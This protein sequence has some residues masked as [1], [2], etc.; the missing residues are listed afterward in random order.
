MK[1][2]ATLAVLSF[3]A[4]SAQA[5]CKNAHDKDAIDIADLKDE[6]GNAVKLG[7]PFV[8]YDEI[9]GNY[10]GYG[11]KNWLTLTK[12]A[13]AGFFWQPMPRNPNVIFLKGTVGKNC[14]VK[15]RSWLT[16]QGRYL[17]PSGCHGG[18]QLEFRKWDKGQCKSNWCYQV[19][20][21]DVEPA[22]GVITNVVSDGYVAFVDANCAAKKFKWVLKRPKIGVSWNATYSLGEL[23]TC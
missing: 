19:G 10:L 13:P 5:W 7:E 14:S 9:Y 18:G 16:H 21:L 2:F 6:C 20:L 8:L 23:Q 3:V 22:N 11:E 12:T 17:A 4:Y 15:G 1:S